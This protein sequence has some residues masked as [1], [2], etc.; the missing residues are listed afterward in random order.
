MT[1]QREKQPDFENRIFL[2]LSAPSP[3]EKIHN[4][5][6]TWHKIEPRNITKKDD[7]EIDIQIEFGK[8]WKCGFYDW[9]VVLLGND[10]RANALLL[11]KPPTTSSFPLVKYNSIIRGDFDDD[12]EPEAA[13]GRFVVQA[14]GIRD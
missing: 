1:V 11:T 4:N 6:L 12:D 10:G 13:Q 7:D 8:F 14:R 9:R 3:L 5:V 2:G